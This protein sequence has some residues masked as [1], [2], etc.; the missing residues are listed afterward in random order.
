MK[1]HLVDDRVELLRAHYA[2]EGALWCA[3][4]LGA[5]AGAI[6]NFAWRHGVK[7]SRYSIPSLAAN[8][9]HSKR[10]TG[11]KRPDQSLVMLGLYAKRKLPVM[12]PER[13][14]KFSEST[15]ASIKR[16]GHPRGFLG[17]THSPETRAKI[18]RKSRKYWES[19]TADQRAQHAEKCCKTAIR[20]GTLYANRRRGTW[21][22]GWRVIG[23]NRKFYRSAWEANYARYLQWLKERGQIE[24]WQHEPRTFWFEQIKRGCRSYLPD[25]IVTERNGDEAYHE[26]KGWMDDRSKT[27]LGR[28]AKYFPEVCVVVI[29]QREYDEIRRK[30]SPIIP[31]WET[32]DPRLLVRIKETP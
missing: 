25:F 17:M 18:G 2:T 24:S 26:V 10:L 5:T 23:G 4:K 16:N 20:N 14:R 12:T 19:L 1:R 3:E 29:K 27:K 28:M 7:G 15:K 31:G 9:E 30:V 22:A 13:R 11:R 21:K 8:A 32:Q 6:R